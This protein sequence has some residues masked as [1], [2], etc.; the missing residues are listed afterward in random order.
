MTSI[1]TIFTFQIDKKSS[2]TSLVD[3]HGE[4]T[5]T[6]VRIRTRTK[7]QIGYNNQECNRQ[8]RVNCLPEDLLE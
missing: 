6:S 7:R 4:R 5:K 8:T 3:K 1:L 2:H